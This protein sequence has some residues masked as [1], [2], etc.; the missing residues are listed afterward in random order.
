MIHFKARITFIADVLFYYNAYLVLRAAPAPSILS[1]VITDRQL[2]SH[3]NLGHQLPNQNV[4]AIKRTYMYIYSYIYIYIC[5]N[6]C[7]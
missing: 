1:H 2:E 3:F 5:V 4:P 7:M 6:V